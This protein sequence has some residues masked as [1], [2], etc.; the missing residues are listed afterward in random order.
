MASDGIA[1]SNVVTVILA[2]SDTP[3]TA[4]DR[5][6]N[7]FSENGILNTEAAQGLLNGLSSSNGNPLIPLIASRGQ[8]GSLNVNPDGSFTYTPNAGYDGSDSFEYMTYDGSRLSNTATVSIT[9]NQIDIPV[10]AGAQLHDS[11][12]LRAYD[13][14]GPEV[15]LL[16]IQ[17]P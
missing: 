10:A 11:C 7:S 5:S 1:H 3:P 17:I 14:G 8:H 16:T 13:H 15:P 2:V 9:V 12:G 4:V 6:C